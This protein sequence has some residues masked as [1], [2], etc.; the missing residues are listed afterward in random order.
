MGSTEC[1]MLEIRP[2][3]TTR[4]TIEDRETENCISKAKFTFAEGCGG[5]WGQHAERG[6][7]SVPPHIPDMIYPAS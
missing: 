7:Q 5:T 2:L 3:K 4:I 6:R 1:D